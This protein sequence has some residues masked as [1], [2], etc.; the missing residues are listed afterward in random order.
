MLKLNIY[1][2]N[3]QS[4]VYILTSTKRCMIEHQDG[5]G[6]FYQHCGVFTVFIS[7]LITLPLPSCAIEPEINIWDTTNRLNGAFENNV[8]MQKLNS[9]NIG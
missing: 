5:G 1:Y 4:S 9:I 7:I 8:H 6:C 2:N 3:L